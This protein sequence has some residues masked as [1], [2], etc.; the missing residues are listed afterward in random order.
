MN[1]LIHINSGFFP[2]ELQCP[3]MCYTP[4]VSLATALVE[5][6]ISGHLVHPKQPKV[7]RP[8]AAFVATL[9][10]YQFTEFMLC[11][12]EQA[13]FWAR[14]G[15]VA[16]GLLP[17]LLLHSFTRLA[18]KKFRKEIYAIPAI[19]ISY[20]VLQ[21]EFLIEAGCNLLTISISHMAFDQ[22]PMM[23]WAFFAYYGLFPIIGLAIYS[24]SLLHK[25][26]G[27]TNGHLR[28]ALACI[29]L[30][31]AGSQVYFLAATWQQLEPQETWLHMILI[32][33][34]IL[35]ALVAAGSIH[36]VRSSRVFQWILIATTASSASTALILHVIFPAFAYDFP[37]IYCH[38][39]LLYGIAAVLIAKQQRESIQKS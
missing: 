39:A 27:F 31:V 29:P 18:G 19:L 28:L 15:Y 32:A 5:F 20:A 13:D 14:T 26:S 37:S 3:T 2:Q 22:A 12:T 38:F 6:S 17:A 36:L 9:G 21:E 34:G 24:R 11:M 30:A 35:I 10:A 8:L 7:L 16:Y 25:P 23:K 4:A 33:T 1:R